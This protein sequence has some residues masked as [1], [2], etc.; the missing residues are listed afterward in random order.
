MAAQVLYGVARLGHDR[1]HHRGP[2][3]HT[4]GATI[5]ILLTHNVVEDNLFDD[6]QFRKY[7]EICFFFSTQIAKCDAS[8]YCLCDSSRTSSPIWTLLSLPWLLRLLPPGQVER[9]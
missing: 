7:V 3:R 6:F 1:W 5:S 9:N 8:G 2:H 4:T